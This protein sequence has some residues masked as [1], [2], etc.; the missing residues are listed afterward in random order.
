MDRSAVRSALQDSDRTV[1]AVVGASLLALLLRVAFL[2]HRVAHFDE[3]RVAYW[4][5][6]YAE[7]GAISY[8]FIVHGPF[9]QY[10]DRWAFALLGHSDFSMRLVVALV[11]AALPLVA[12]LFRSR[13]RDGEVVAM[14]ALLAFNPVLIY[15]SRFYRSSLLVAAF[16]TAALGFGVAAADRDRPLLLYPAAVFAGLGFASKENAVLYVL[17]WLGAGALLLDYSLLNPV[18]AETGRGAVAGRVDRLRALLTGRT[19]RAA[20]DRVRGWALHVGGGAVAFAL[21]CL[22]F[23]APRAPG[24]GVGLWEAVFDPRLFPQLL[25]AT[26][27][28]VSA[29]LDY[30]FGGSVEPGCHADN[31][32]DGY[33]C[34]LEQFVGTLGRYAA[35]ISAFSVLGFV[36]ERYGTVRPRPLVMFASYWGV[37]SVLGYPLGTDIYG[38]WITVNA[39]VPLTVPAAVGLAVVGRWGWDAFVAEDRTGTALIAVV[40]LLVAALLVVPTV[41][42]VYLHP[43]AEANGLVQYAQPQQDVRPTVEDLGAIAAANDGTDLLFYGD[44]IVADPETA[45]PPE[46]DCTRMVATLPLQWYIRADDVETECA[47]DAPAL[48]ER[49]GG[50]DDPPVVIAAVDREGEVVDHLDGDYERRYHHLR[51]MG[52]EVVVF[53]DR[54]ALA[55]AEAGRFRAS[56]RAR[57]TVA[58]ATRPGVTD[59]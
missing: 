45:G 14:A 39:L 52:R 53:V 49:L 59:G 34:Y 23:Y 21:V 42:S 26:W 48:E 30:W 38:A 24:P 58:M 32:V 5:M 3:G 44:E 40:F 56:Q 57:S 47:Y 27:A 35:V 10:A 28:D 41:G 4:A 43:T 8:R 7:T 6:E 11:G 25:D 36:V 37:A 29:G 33:V 51:T 12:L 20:R 17:C 18:R 55:D 16:M 22:F 2:G 9:A 15:Y 1:R 46:P 50:S 31:L 54:D 19:S 13:L